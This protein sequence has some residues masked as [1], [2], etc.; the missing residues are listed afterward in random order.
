M[1]IGESSTVSD[2]NFY[3]YCLQCVSSVYSVPS[4]V[5]QCQLDSLSTAA[6]SIVDKS[7]C[8]SGIVSIFYRFSRK[9]F[10]STLLNDIASNDKPTETVSLVLFRLFLINRRFQLQSFTLY[11]Y[12][13]L[14]KI[15]IVFCKKRFFTHCS[16]VL[17]IPIE[18]RRF[19][20][21]IVQYPIVVYLS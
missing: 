6:L 20:T 5:E 18:Q 8:I 7:C 15:S 12:I 9:W 2:S 11:F 16:Q 17:T 3:R 14:V 13:Y 1:R 19:H 21:F 10:S 4:E